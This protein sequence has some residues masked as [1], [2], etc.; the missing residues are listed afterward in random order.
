M[1]LFAP[2]ILLPLALLSS[3]R[4]SAQPRPRA[5]TEQAMFGPAAV[6]LHRVFTRVRDWTGDGTPDGVEALVELRDQ[7]GDP[8]KAAGKLVFDLYKLRSPAPDP[9]GV[10]IAGPFV[11][12]LSTLEDQKNYWSR[13]SRTYT[14]QLE[15]PV[16]TDQSYV[17]TVSFQPMQGGR[18]F[19]QMILG[20]AGR[21]GGESGDQ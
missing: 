20:K 17:L 16:K 10:E 13:T 15:A 6:R 14:F 11:A 7:L 9:R 19:D 21:P 5:A 12:D 1:R 18:L 2:L 3:C 4:S 8:T